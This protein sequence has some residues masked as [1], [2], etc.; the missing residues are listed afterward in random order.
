MKVN[1]LGKTPETLMWKVT[2]GGA[3]VRPAELAA[4]LPAMPGPG[5]VQ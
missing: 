2:H 1:N 5:G 4:D 3:R